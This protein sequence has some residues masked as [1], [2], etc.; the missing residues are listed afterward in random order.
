MGEGL[1]GD[2]ELLGGYEAGVVGDLIVFVLLY[3][4][5]QIY[6][7]LERARLVDPLGNALERDACRV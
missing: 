1:G 7:V 5:F 6:E 3:E 2:T 4:V